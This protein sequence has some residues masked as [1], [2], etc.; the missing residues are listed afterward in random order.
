MRI[1][2]EGLASIIRRAKHGGLLVLGR[3]KV[4]RLYTFDS[5]VC[6]VVPVNAMVLQITTSGALMSLLKVDFAGLQ[7]VK[8]G[9]FLPL[10]FVCHI[11]IDDPPQLS[12]HACQPSI[13]L[14]LLTT[15]TA[16]SSI[17]PAL[18]EPLDS[19]NSVPGTQL[20]MLRLARVLPFNRRPPPRLEAH[21]K[22]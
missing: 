21:T 14:R 15:N 16:G 6:W 13:G 20:L 4:L 7:L 17:E 22:F 3:T 11:Y 2:L 1:L 18:C 9:V 10:S 8:P 12:I 5:A 19:F